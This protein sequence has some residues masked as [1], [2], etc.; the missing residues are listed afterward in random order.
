MND[1]DEHSRSFSGWNKRKCCTPCC[2]LILLVVFGVKAK[3]FFAVDLIMC[4]D[5]PKIIIASNQPYNLTLQM[6][7]I[8]FESNSTAKLCLIPDGSDPTI[9]G[10]T[11]EIKDIK[12]WKVIDKA[13]MNNPKLPLGR[14]ELMF[15]ANNTNDIGAFTNYTDTFNTWGKAACDKELP[16]SIPYNYLV[17]KDNSVAKQRGT[18]AILVSSDQIDEDSAPIF[19]RITAEQWTYSPFW[20]RYNLLY[21]S[22][23]FYGFSSG[24]A[25]GYA[26]GER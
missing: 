4:Q 14:K 5:M 2:G 23:C 9:R 16:K 21:A 26:L 25:K 1:L 15:S 24:F 7:S 22:L 8:K 19:V 18:K 17:N 12:Y 13:F 6:D 20:K 3:D 11:V 10:V